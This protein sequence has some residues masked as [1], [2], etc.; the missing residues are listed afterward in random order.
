MFKPNRF[1]S[2]IPYSYSTFKI[3]VSSSQIP[4]EKRR[5]EKRAEHSSFLRVA[6]YTTRPGLAVHK[7]VLTNRRQEKLIWYLVS[8][9][10]QSYIS[11]LGH[12][13]L[14]LKYH[15]TC[16]QRQYNRNCLKSFSFLLGEVGDG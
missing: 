3:K 6:C 12:Y 1:Y 13:V 9:S 5:E 16:W 10:L 4:R 15:I 11:L 14:F 2:I 7:L 8:I